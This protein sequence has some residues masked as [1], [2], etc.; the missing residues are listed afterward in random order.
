MEADTSPITAGEGEGLPDRGGNL[1]LILRAHL[2]ILID[3]QIHR[4]D[5]LGVL[6]LIFYAPLRLGG[7]LGSLLWG[8][9]WGRGCRW[10]IGD[11]VWLL[12]WVGRPVQNVEPEGVPP[13]VEGVCRLVGDKEKLLLEGR[14]GPEDVD[15][16][17]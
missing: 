2:V 6:L 10:N 8:R 5:Q 4:V 9:C 16:A 15:I 7:C 12:A 14:D 17:L 13:G 3:V 1:D 11:D